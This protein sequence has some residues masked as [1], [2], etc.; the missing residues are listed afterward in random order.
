[1][2][3]HINFTTS[4]MG[5]NLMEIYLKK[6]TKTDHTFNKKLLLIL[7]TYVIIYIINLSTKNKM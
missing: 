4:F 7:K 5:S 3:H 2:Q 1:M 6:K